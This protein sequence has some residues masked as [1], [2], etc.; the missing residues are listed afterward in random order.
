MR[1]DPDPPTEPPTRDPPAPEQRLYRFAKLDPP[2][3]I[4]RGAHD[5]LT[6]AWAEADQ[7]RA[8]AREE[9][10]AAGY[11]EGL[12][13]AQ[14]E[15]APAL[16]ALGEAARALAALRDELVGTLESQAA[17]LALRL[18]EQILTATLELEPERV[19]DITRSALRRL[20]DR[21]RVAV[22]VNPADLDLLS[23]QA[24]RLQHELGGIEHLDVQSDRRIERGGAIVRTESGEIDVTIASQMQRARELVAAALADA[25]P[26]VADFDLTELVDVG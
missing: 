5:V 8:R 25:R 3:R 4:H 10:E 9:G 17:E 22:L 11:A 23:G 6:D 14:A 20:T 13:R 16:A 18:A 7:I 15:A 21:H 26:D 1:R 19:V 12:A 24:S 2:I